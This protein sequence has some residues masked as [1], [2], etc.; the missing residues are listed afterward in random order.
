MFTFLYLK[1]VLQLAYSKMQGRCSFSIQMLRYYPH[2]KEVKG[3][4]RKKKSTFFIVYFLWKAVRV[5]CTSE[6][7]LCT[8]QSYIF[9][10]CHTMGAHGY[11]VALLFTAFKKG[12]RDSEMQTIT[13][14]SLVFNLALLG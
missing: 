3:T 10:P 12:A 14:P 4:L 5:L 6:T 9:I 2:L 7:S 8:L 11:H 13:F 1:N